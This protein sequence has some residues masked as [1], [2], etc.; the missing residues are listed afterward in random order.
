MAKIVGAAT[1]YDR[2][3]ATAG[4]IVLAPVPLV[5]VSLWLEPTSESAPSLPSTLTSP[6]IVSGVHLTVSVVVTRHVAAGIARLDHLAAAAILLLSFSTSMAGSG[7]GNADDV[8]AG[9]A[10]CRLTIEATA[11][12]SGTPVFDGTPRDRLA[13]REHDEIRDVE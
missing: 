12:S 13:E 4:Q 9:A 8:D 3:V 2:I 7:A 6:V 1:A 11:I 10:W 5:M